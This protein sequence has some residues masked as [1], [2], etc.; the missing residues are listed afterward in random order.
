MWQVALFDFPP[1]NLMTIVH[2]F[3]VL[4]LMVWLTLLHHLND[5]TDL[6]FVDVLISLLVFVKCTPLNH[7]LVVKYV[8]PL[9]TD[10]M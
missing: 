7:R 1:P 5:Q 9:F 8:S 3:S 2:L 10:L 6:V 4:I